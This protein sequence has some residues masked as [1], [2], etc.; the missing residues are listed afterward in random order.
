MLIEVATLAW[1]FAFSS[2][3]DFALVAGGECRAL[4]DH[5]DL[6]AGDSSPLPCS[7]LCEQWDA[8]I[9][10]RLVTTNWIRTIAGAFAVPSSFSTSSNAGQRQFE[11][12]LIL[13]CRLLLRE[14]A[15]FCG[16]KGDNI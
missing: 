2:A 6:D 8:A 14:R 5:L 15:L 16:A 11:V 12:P 10:A 3:R 1:L 7:Q 9:H 13:K 4:G